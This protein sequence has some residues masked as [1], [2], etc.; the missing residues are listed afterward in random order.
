[1]ITSFRLVMPPKMK[2]SAITKSL[3]LRAFAAEVSAPEPVATGIETGA[4]T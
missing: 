3:R 2:N 4:V 1:M